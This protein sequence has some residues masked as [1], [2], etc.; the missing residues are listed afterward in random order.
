V[1]IG[2]SGGKDSAVLMKVLQ[3]LNSRYDYG[4]ELYLLS[5]DEGISGYRDH[6]LEEVKFHSETSGLQLKVLSYKQLYNWSMDEIVAVAGRK[7]NCTFCGVFRRQALDRGAW[8]L[9]VDLVATG[10]NADD[11]A[12]T[13]L[14]NM[15]RGDVG[16]LSRCTAIRTADDPSG[17]PRVKPLK[18]QYEAEIVK[19]A[20]H[21]KTRYFSTECTYAPGAH[22]GHIRE[23]LRAA[24]KIRP[25]VVLDTIA[26]GEVLE[27]AE[28]VKVPIKSRCVQC[29]YIS[30][31][32][33]CKACLLLEGL[34]SGRPLLGIGKTKDGKVKKFKKVKSSC[35]KQECTKETGESGCG[36]LDLSNLRIKNIKQ[37]EASDLF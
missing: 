13:V 24:T 7:S 14:M 8:Q 12:E 15:L 35:D 3:V 36:E 10:H 5:I 31:Q 20:R 4:L 23:F 25:Q 17:I 28:G 11:I 1:A 27:V 9:G 6:S 2:A 19:Y 22:R 26:A 37:I 33:V 32:P 21:T 34:N 29:D 30:S 16:R 18:Y